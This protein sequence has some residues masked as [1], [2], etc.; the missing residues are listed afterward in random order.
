MIKPTALAQ[1][2]LDLLILKIKE[3]KKEAANWNRLSA[4]ISRVAPL[5]GA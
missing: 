4:A 2:D 3:L 5:K 1:G